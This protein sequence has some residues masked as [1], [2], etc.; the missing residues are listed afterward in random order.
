MA[1]DVRWN[2]Q[3]RLIISDVDETVA[4]LYVDASPDM[5]KELEKILIEGKV[6]F[7]ISGQSVQSVKK[8]IVDHIPTR[9]K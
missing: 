6:I 7:F 8:R 3:V 1:S 2:D 5:C 9:V 4:D